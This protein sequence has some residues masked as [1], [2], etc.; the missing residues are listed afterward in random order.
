MFVLLREKKK[1]RKELV[2]TTNNIFCCVRSTMKLQLN[3]SLGVFAPI[4]KWYFKLFAYLPGFVYY[5]LSKE[6]LFNS[7]DF[8][9]RGCAGIIDVFILSS[10]R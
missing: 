1:W 3:Y 6:I 8:I 2:K 4:Y 5:F 9:L 10:I 7:V